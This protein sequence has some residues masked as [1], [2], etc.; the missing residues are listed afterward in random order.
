MCHHVGVKIRSHINK[1]M[2][3]FCNRKYTLSTQVHH[4]TPQIKSI[5]QRKAFVGVEETIKFKLA[6]Q[7]RTYRPVRNTL[8]D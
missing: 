3:I 6:T 8:G 7:I 5:Y 2:T 4:C 1:A